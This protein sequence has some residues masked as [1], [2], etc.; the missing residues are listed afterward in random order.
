[1][2][3]N[4]WIDPPLPAVSR[5][6]NSNHQPLPGFLDPPRGIAELVQQRLQRVLIF[7]LAE[8]PHCPPP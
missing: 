1:M 5:P 2:L 7:F 4:I 6:S 8:M 3:A